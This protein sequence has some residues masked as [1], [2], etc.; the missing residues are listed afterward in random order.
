M[1]LE[2]RQYLFLSNISNAIFPENENKKRGGGGGGG[3]IS[4]K[5]FQ[6]KLQMF[7]RY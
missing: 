2:H 3:V 5:R 1:V 7:L 6:K 4:N